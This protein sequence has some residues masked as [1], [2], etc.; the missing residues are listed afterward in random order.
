[1]I[2]VAVVVDGEQD[3]AVDAIAVKPDEIPRRFRQSGELLG[4]IGAV[5]AVDEAPDLL[6]LADEFAGEDAKPV[7]FAFAEIGLNQQHGSSS[8]GQRRALSKQVPA[9]GRYYDSGRIV[10]FS[11]V[12]NPLSRS[13]HCL[14]G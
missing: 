13:R 11:P 10:F 7:N 8:R 14:R 2:H 6:A 4:R 3:F 9:G 5:E 12:N 1:M